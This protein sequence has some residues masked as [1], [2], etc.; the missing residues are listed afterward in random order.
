VAADPHT[1]H[2][3]DDPIIF[4]LKLRNENYLFE[5]RPARP[6]N[7]SDSGKCSV[8]PHN[9]QVTAVEIGLYLSKTWACQQLGE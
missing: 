5:T 1:L 8:D 6:T 3:K 7:D 9:H 2:Y 4:N